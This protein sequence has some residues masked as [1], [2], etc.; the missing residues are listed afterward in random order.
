MSSSETTGNSSAAYT[1]CF[2]EDIGL[3]L[4]LIVSA[5][6]TPP[7][8]DS[9]EGDCFR[10]LTTVRLRYD[11]LLG[12]PSLSELTGHFIQPTRTFTSELP[13]VWSPAPSSD[14]TT[15][16]TGQSAPAGLA[17]GRSST[18]FTALYGQ[19]LPNRVRCR[20][21]RLGT[22]TIIVHNNVGGCMT[23]V[24]P[25]DNRLWRPSGRGPVL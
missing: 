9:G 24:E 19:S 11:L 25:N 15:V 16:P 21:E 10:G 20:E 1:Q 18:S 13:T 6:P 14:I 12:L 7:H 4:Q 3:Q 17:P 5:F 8:S 22:P 2:T 23:S